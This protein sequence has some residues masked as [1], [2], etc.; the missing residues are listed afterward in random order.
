MCRFTLDFV[1]LLLIW[2]FFSFL[3]AVHENVHRHA[4]RMNARPINFV[5][6]K[7]MNVM[8][9]LYL[10]VY[11][12]HQIHH[13]QV[14]IILCFA[15]FLHFCLSIYAISTKAS[16]IP[17]FLLLSLSLFW[18]SSVSFFHMMFFPIWFS[19]KLYFGFPIIPINTAHEI[20]L[21]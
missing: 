9:P 11:R 19:I 6:M 2:F 14:I 17:L 4:H 8:L 12:V 3:I 21:Q 13:I 7:W 15:S 18:G 16:F 10:W 20:S 5:A 1:N